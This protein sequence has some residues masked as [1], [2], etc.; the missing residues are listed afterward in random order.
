[1]SCLIKIVYQRNNRIIINLKNKKNKKNKNN[2]KCLRH[3]LLY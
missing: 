2:L 1:M 3:F